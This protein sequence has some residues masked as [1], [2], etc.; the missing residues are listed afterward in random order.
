MYYHYLKAASGWGN[1]CVKLVRAILDE[2]WN[3]ARALAEE[4]SQV[5]W[6]G[7]AIRAK[8]Q[9]E[10]RKGGGHMHDDPGT[11][12]SSGSAAGSEGGAFADVGL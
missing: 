4:Y 2:K 7:R 5:P 1:K 6:V 12:G 8:S 11:G 3:L 9:H 10:Y